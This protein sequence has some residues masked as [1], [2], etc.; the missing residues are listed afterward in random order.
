MRKQLEIALPLV[1][2]Y[3]VCLAEARSDMIAELAL[4]KD[5]RKKIG[6]KG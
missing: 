2:F 6:C 4:V 5:G 1:C 3:K